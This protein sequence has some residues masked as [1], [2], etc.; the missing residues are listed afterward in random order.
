M[1]TNQQTIEESEKRWPQLSVA[2]DPEPALEFLESWSRAHDPG[3][4]GM[5]EMKGAFRE[6][7]MDRMKEVCVSELIDALA[8]NVACIM[9][10][11]IIKE[12]GK[13]GQ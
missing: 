10:E 13:E 1:R 6:Y 5:N 7:L 2:M 11:K 4:N 12:F 8:E 3:P 9:L